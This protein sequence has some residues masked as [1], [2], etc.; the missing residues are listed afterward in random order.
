[1][2]RIDWMLIR[3]PRPDKKVAKRLDELEG[4]IDA[5]IHEATQRVLSESEVDAL[6]DLE[7]RFDGATIAACEAA[8]APRYEEAPDGENRLV[9]EYAMTETDLELDEYLETR[10][11]EFDCER[12]PHASSYS[13]YPMDPCEITA[14]ALL[15]ILVDDPLKRAIRRPMGPDDMRRLADEL[16]LRRTEG[17]FQALTELDAGDYL[18]KC[19]A[20]LRLWARLGFGV[21]PVDF[22][23]LEPIQ[24]PEGPLGTPSGSTSHLLH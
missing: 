19:V 23:A 12:C 17:R 8:H 6:C 4:R 1:M 10:R 5:R 24:T 18:D 3:P 15:E 13:L 14:G 11:R 22:D 16:E 21:R 20:F 2:K 7:D 9:D